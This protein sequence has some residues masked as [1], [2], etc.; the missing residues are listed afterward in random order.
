[1][2]S[3]PDFTPYFSTNSPPNDS[4][5][6]LIE[7]RIQDETSELETLDSE[8]AALQAKLEDLIRQRH[9]LHKRRFKYKVILSAVRRLPPELLGGIFYLVA[10]ANWDDTDPESGLRRKP[11]WTLGLVCRPWRAAAL[12]Y[13][14]LWDTIRIHNFANR[15]QLREQL[16]RAK[17]APLRVWIDQS[18]GPVSE[19]PFVLDLILPTSAR[20]VALQLHQIGGTDQHTEWMSSLEGRLLLLERLEVFMSTQ[21]SF[22]PDLFLSAPRLSR[23]LLLSASVTDCSPP[24][25][26]LPWE[27]ITHFRGAYRP[28]EHFTIL[29]CAS[30]LVECVLGTNGGTYPT[31]EDDVL[32]PHLRC[33]RLENTSFLDRITAPSLCALCVWC[34][35]EGGLVDAGIEKVVPFVRRSGCTL[36]KLALFDCYAEPEA[37]LSLLRELSTLESVLLEVHT[38]DQAQQELLDALMVPPRPAAGVILL[39]KLRSLIYGFPP[40]FNATPRVVE[41]VRSRAMRSHEIRYPPSLFALSTYALEALPGSLYCRFASA[42]GGGCGRSMERKRPSSYCTGAVGGFL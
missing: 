5:I 17:Q 7:Q 1:M 3:R 39:P 41:M 40:N 4:D 23:V 20:W 12:G 28:A 9:A 33:I 22:P 2:A 21:A 35:E 34:E 30:N 24:D 13:T 16:E 18:Y 27:Q 37:T 25:M 29:Q 32:L 6:P 31:P 42:S 10:T 36:T 11:P 8:I 26:E 38:Q 14:A 15:A 19:T